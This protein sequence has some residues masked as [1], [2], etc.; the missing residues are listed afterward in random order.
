MLIVAN[1]AIQLHGRIPLLSRTAS[2]QFFIVYG[3]QFWIADPWACAAASI[4]IV[5]NKRR[6]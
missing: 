5:R 3:G 1:G 2:V 4:P 6:D